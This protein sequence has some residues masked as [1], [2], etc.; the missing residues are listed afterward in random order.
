M[1]CPACERPA[2]A[3]VLVTLL[4]PG[5]GTAR[6]ARVCKTCKRKGLTVCAV[7]VPAKVVH[8]DGGEAARQAVIKLRGLLNSYCKGANLSRCAEL[9]AGNEGSARFFEGKAEGFEAAIVALGSV[10]YGVA[11]VLVALTLGA[12]GGPFGTTQERGDGAAFDASPA[13]AAT[14]PPD[15]DAASFQETGPA[16]FDAADALPEAAGPVVCV[17]G[18]A[19]DS[20]EGCNGASG[21]LTI[22]W[23]GGDCPAGTP[24][25]SGVCPP[26]AVCNVGL[27]APRLGVCR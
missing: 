26:G 22:T 16:P 6:R 2:R 1:I 11:L 15:G 20:Y 7:V 3:S 8:V 18:D 19:G 9:A 27:T 10:F 14:V 5:S 21:P 12:C 4:D 25:A 17:A 13:E 23:D 24:D